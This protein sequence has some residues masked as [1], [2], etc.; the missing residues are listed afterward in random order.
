MAELRV[1][2]V[3]LP[4]EVVD[5]GGGR[6]AGQVF[7]PAQAS[8]HS[9][10]TRPVEWINSPGDF[11]PFLPEGA[12]SAVILNKS[13]VVLLVVGASAD[14]DEVA[15]EEGLPRRR[16][17]I[18]CGS[19]SFEGTLL[20]DM[21]ENQRRLQD[22]LNRPERFVEL[23]DG[24]RHLLVRKEAITRLHENLEGD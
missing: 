12:T 14:A 17:R 2:T 22:Y 4:A 3:S 20:L 7:M 24:D 9:G 16:V 8:A 19:Q 6:S 11:F 15:E 1:P 5:A 21:P 23:R 13:Q 10:A 18:E